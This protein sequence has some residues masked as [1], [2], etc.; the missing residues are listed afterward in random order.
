MKYIYFLLLLFVGL[1]CNSKNSKIDKV[2]LSSLQGSST[3]KS[4]SALPDWVALG[5]VFE[6]K[7]D[8]VFFKVYFDKQVNT[9]IGFKNA[10]KMAW[11][12][13]V[14]TITDKLGVNTK[15]QSLT[16]LL[17]EYN[18]AE[19]LFLSDDTNLQCISSKMKI[20]NRYWELN[21]DNN[22]SLSYDIYLKV[23]LPINFL[24]KKIHETLLMK[25]DRLRITNR[26]AIRSVITNISFIK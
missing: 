20:V 12:R 6:K 16:N 3:I 2:N 25:L 15:V 1:S 18:F 24:E 23:V 14:F 5:P 19:L 11:Q 26:L 13:V 4:S 17:S 21:K 7:N 8:N 10:E 9:N 22:K